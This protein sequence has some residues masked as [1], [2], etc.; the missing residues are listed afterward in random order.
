MSPGLTGIDSN[1]LVYAF[2]RSE[3]EKHEAARKLVSELIESG[4]VVLSVQNLTEFFFVSTNHIEQP[5]GEEEALDIIR[6]F[7]KSDATVESMTP[8][9]SIKAAK[10][11]EKKNTDF[12]DALLTQTLKQNE[13][14]KIITEN[15]QDFKD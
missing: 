13:V 4:K 8:E 14:E 1:I 10:V 6:D 2:D 11:H 9:N 3:G 15:T 12:W 5:I 7:R